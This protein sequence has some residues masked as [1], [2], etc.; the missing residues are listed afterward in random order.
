[1]PY[2]EIK[3][4]AIADHAPFTI[5][6]PRGNAILEIQGL[7]NM[8]DAKPTGLAAQ[9]EAKFL[10]LEDHMFPADD[11]TSAIRFGKLEL[12]GNKATLLIGNSQRLI[13]DLKEIKP[14]LALIKFDNNDNEGSQ[15]EIIDV[16]KYK[17]VFTGRPL[18]IM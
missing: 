6:T 11:D 15:V 2:A 17:L 5:S 14:P 4:S 18:P 1:M 8:P 10:E 3:H 16:I 9:E 7:L 12:E 13:G